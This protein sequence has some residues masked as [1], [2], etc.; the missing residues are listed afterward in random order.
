MRIKEFLEKVEQLE[1]PQSDFYILGGGALLLYGFREEAK[2]IDLCISME[3]FH[4][5]IWEKRI[6]PEMKNDS[7]FYPL[8]LDRG[9]EVVPNL[10]S[11]FKCVKAGIYNVE[12]LRQILMFKQKRKEEKDVKDIDKI[13]NYLQLNPDYPGLE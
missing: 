7:G 11:D 2:D 3:L 4:K 6:H 12:N 13:E 5:L 9:V 8:D 1:L 10:K